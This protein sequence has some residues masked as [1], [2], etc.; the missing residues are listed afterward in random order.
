E[1]ASARCLPDHTMPLPGEMVVPALGPGVVQGDW[2]PTL[3]VFR[4]CPRRFVQVTVRA[5]QRKVIQRRRPAVGAR[6]DVL[7]VECSP[8]RDWCRRQ[9]SHRCPAR[10]ATC[11]TTSD[12]GLTAPAPAGATPGPSATTWSRSAP[13]AP[14][15]RTVRPR[16][17]RPPCSG[18]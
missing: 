7:R 8:W 16:S 13:R 18:P 12:Q 5:R 10:S 11:C 9:Y 3:W 1:R 6:D 2:G 17:A 14:P 4:L 15:A